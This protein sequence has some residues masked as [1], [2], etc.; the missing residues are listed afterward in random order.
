MLKEFIEQY[1]QRVEKQFP[2]M[3]NSLAGPQRLKDA[4][5]YSLEAGGKRIRPMLLYAVLHGY[6][7]PAVMGDAAACALEM[8]HTYSLI[9]DDLPSM[10]NDDMRRGMP[11]NH[12]RFDEATAVLAGDAMLTHSFHLIAADQHLDDAVKVKLIE[13]L[14]RA[15]GAGG[16]VGGQMADMLAER[17]E[18][19]LAADLEN[20]HEHK[21]GDLLA[22][23]LQMGAVAAGADE[24]A[25]KHLDLF[26]RHIG[27]S[28]Q[29]KDDLLD[30]EGDEAL[31]GKPVGSDQTNHKHTYVRLLGV[32]GA[33]KRLDEHT[34]A[35]LEALQHV[36]ADTSILSALAH[37]IRTR[38]Q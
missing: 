29:I 2:T 20:I 23:G 12:R 5:L 11:T 8:V 17:E 10:D 19:I 6:G 35:A 26:G 36:H 13:Q 21:T 32:E 27:L 1:K 9:H 30:V 28:F 25:Q 33:K 38:E 24:E 16:M 4:M 34:E 15:S 22:V 18:N 7:R 31:I 14:S 3:I 37:Y